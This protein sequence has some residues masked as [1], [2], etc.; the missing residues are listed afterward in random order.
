MSVVLMSV[1]NQFDEK[2]ILRQWKKLG[3]DVPNTHVRIE[4]DSNS[5]VFQARNFCSSYLNHNFGKK[6]ADLDLNKI[7]D[8]NLALDCYRF[9]EPDSINDIPTGRL[10]EFIATYNYIERPHICKDIVNNSCD[11][12]GM[13]GFEFVGALSPTV[14]MIFEPMIYQIAESMEDPSQEKLISAHHTLINTIQNSKLN[15]F[16]KLVQLGQYKIQFMDLEGLGDA[17]QIKELYEKAM[18]DYSEQKDILNKDKKL[19]QNQF[20][21][22]KEALTLVNKAIETQ[23][24]NIHTSKPLDENASKDIILRIKLEQNHQN[25]VQLANQLLSNIVPYD[26]IIKSM[27]VCTN[28]A[29][30]FMHFLGKHETAQEIAKV[31][32]AAITIFHSIRSIQA[33][34]ILGKVNSVFTAITAAEPY[35]AILG[36]VYSLFSNNS[37]NSMQQAITSLSNQIASFE[38]NV[39]NQFDFLKKMQQIMHKDTMNCLANIFNNQQ[40]QNFQ[41]ES[42]RKD[43]GELRNEVMFLKKITQVSFYNL[44]TKFDERLS[45][46]EVIFQQSEH[47]HLIEKAFS[48]KKFFQT[49]EMNDKDWE[50]AIIESYKMSVISSQNPLFT[51]NEKLSFPAPTNSIKAA[52]SI[53]YLADR[54]KIASSYANP[55]IWKAGVGILLQ[56]ISSS[57]T[58][59]RRKPFTEKETERVREIITE[60]RKINHFIHE[61]GNPKFISFILNKYI[62]YLLAF[63]K[64]IKSKIRVSENQ[65]EAKFEKELLNQLDSKIIA[66]QSKSM[67]YFGTILPLPD[68]YSHEQ[69]KKVKK[70]YLKRKEKNKS[71]EKEQREF[72]KSKRRHVQELKSKQD[73]INGIKVC[74][75]SKTYPTKKRVRARLCIN[76]DMLSL[77]QTL[78]N[79]EISNALDELDRHYHFIT[80]CLHLA[81]HTETPLFQ[82]LFDNKLIKNKQDVLNY[83]NH[84][85]SNANTKNKNYLTD[86]LN[87]TIEMIEKVMKRLIHAIE[88]RELVPEYPEITK[89]MSVLEFLTKGK[90]PK[91]KSKSDAMDGMGKIE[92]PMRPIVQWQYQDNT[93][94]KCL[95]GIVNGVRTEFEEFEAASD[96]D[97]GFHVIGYN[98]NQVVEELLKHTDESAARSELVPEILNSLGNGGLVATEKLRVHYK[99]YL[100]HQNEEPTLLEEANALIKTHEP[101]AEHA[102]RKTIKDKLNE[103]VFK[104]SDWVQRRNCVEMLIRVRNHYQLEKKYEMT[105]QQE[106]QTPEMYEFYVNSLR[107]APAWLGYKSARLMA[108]YKGFNLYIWSRKNPNSTILELLESYEVAQPKNY[109]HMLHTNGATHFNLL[110]L[111]T[112]KKNDE[113]IQQKSNSSGQMSLVPAPNPSIN[114]NDDGNEAE[115]PG[116]AQAGQ[117]LIFR[118]NEPLQQFPLKR[119]RE[120]AGLDVSIQADQSPAK[121]AKNA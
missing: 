23:T 33:A 77:V 64:K 88:K 98:R 90:K 120:A 53:N 45:K 39:M 54:A 97:C 87:T 85:P 72:E 30:L 65:F 47:Y 22:E 58:K 103:L 41:L 55:E 21:S 106:A 113:V 78:N 66:E 74:A 29:S 95:V 16:Q 60:G 86:E 38:R 63:K 79:N 27:E 101:N 35:V 44:S 32:S 107:K 2:E 92:N 61:L 50:N 28:G 80:A 12:L 25:Q 102:G 37:S 73:K 4:S 68:R 51:L 11:F 81:F 71:I 3:G 82:F 17:K 93:S 24:N 19:L 20:T 75:F 91:L 96:N 13:V 94:M 70:L 110:G 18:L 56:L 5:K 36:A 57:A 42:L 62:E 49:Y 1:D 31:G 26:D 8:R 84:Y 10:A 83:L 40:F 114:R 108:R 9:L 48:M 43:V 52:F 111:Q 15:T 105:L 69:P 59:N 117:P 6:V 118:Q 67:P 34:S 46:L 109:V 116:M 76:E 115:E 104:I 119:N 112:K 100:S 7:E 121:R 14:R 99:L 89:L